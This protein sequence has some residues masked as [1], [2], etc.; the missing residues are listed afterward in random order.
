MTYATLIDKLC[1]YNFS[2]KLEGRADAKAALK[3][4]F[5]ETN[6]SLLVTYHIFIVIKNFSNIL[7]CPLWLNLLIYSLEILRYAYQRRYLFCSNHYCFLCYQKELMSRIK[8]K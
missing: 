3:N 7:I 1:M 2:L 8:V 5:L 4:Y 6:K